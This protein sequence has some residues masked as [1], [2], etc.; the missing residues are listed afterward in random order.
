MY[1][2]CNGEVDWRTLG[3]ILTAHLM[4]EVSLEYYKIHTLQLWSYTCRLRDPRASN[5]LGF[6]IIDTAVV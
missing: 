3:N 4:G 6:G 1:T 5:Y 2:D